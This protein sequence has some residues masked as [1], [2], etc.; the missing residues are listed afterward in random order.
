[1]FDKKWKDFADWC[2]TSPEETPPIKS[3]MSY[4]F[5]PPAQPNSIE[6][7]TWSDFIEAAN[8]EIDQLTNQTLKI[9]STANSIVTNR[10][11]DVSTYKIHTNNTK[12]SMH[13]A[14]INIRPSPNNS[15]ALTK[16]K[17]EIDNLSIGSVEVSENNIPIDGLIFKN[18]RIQ[19]LILSSHACVTL[20]DVSIGELQFKN[21]GGFNER[22]LVA[23][24]YL[25]VSGGCIL[26]IDCPLPHA[27]NPF[28]GSVIIKNVFLPRTSKEFPI[29]DSQP[30]KNITHHLRAIENTQAANIFHAAELAIERE[31][32]GWSNK[33]VS[34]IYEYSSDCGAS[35][36][37]PFLWW[38]G[39]LL[40]SAGGIWYV[41]GAVLTLEHDAYKGF[42]N[43][44]VDC[45][46]AR[47][48]YLSLQSMANPLGLFSSKALVIAKSGGL[49][50]WLVIQ[51]IIS[52]VLI[53][54]MISAIRRR[55]KIQ[56]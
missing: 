30:Y 14:C 52:V 7:A 31:L 11:D 49:A 28:D 23:V 55:F 33:L 25:K 43:S 54:L 27:D 24:K 56:N 20:Q 19:K 16:L 35:W 8:L 44:L 46:P 21:L 10:T 12:T 40:I 4:L 18:C 5:N 51:S 13:V 50:I 47:A 1:M 48:F 36:F 41:D 17:L 6:A 3:N 53:T 9:I 39:I 32:L 29:R 42:R 2:K 26:N 45:A 37:R 38:F 22:R 34:Y 15:S